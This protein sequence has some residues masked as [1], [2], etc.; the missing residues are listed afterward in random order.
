MALSNV[1]KDSITRPMFNTDNADLRG[2]KPSLHNAA[3]GLYELL[4]VGS[5]PF[6]AGEAPKVTCTQHTRVTG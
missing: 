6:V 3:Q 1:R 5:D 4:Q 2:R